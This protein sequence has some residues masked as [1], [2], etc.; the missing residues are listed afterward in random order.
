MK[1]K[2]RRSL[3]E[4]LP[5]LQFKPNNWSLAFVEDFHLEGDQYVISIGYDGIKDNVS[6]RLRPAEARA[7]AKWILGLVGDEDN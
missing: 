1:T 5:G 7:L 4:Q 3:I 2:K 6:A